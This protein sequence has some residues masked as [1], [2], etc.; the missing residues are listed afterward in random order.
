[1]GNTFHTIAC[2]FLGAKGN[3]LYMTGT[4]DKSL[5]IAAPDDLGGQNAG[6]APTFL[7]LPLMQSGNAGGY[8]LFD[9]GVW[10]GGKALFVR[11]HGWGLAITGFPYQAPGSTEW[12]KLA[13]P[14]DTA[15]GCD[16]G[17]CIM[18]DG[19]HIRALT[20]PGNG[21]NPSIAAVS[22]DLAAGITGKPA[23]VGIGA[24][25]HLVLVR[26]K[27]GKAYRTVYVSGS[28]SFSGGW[29]DEGGY[30]NAGASPTCV[31]QGAQALCVI[32]GNDGRL[33]AKLL[34][35]TSGL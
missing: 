34:A 10:D 5:S 33:Y 6:A 17:T 27:D 7:K 4:D 32:Q 31:A 28:N 14:F 9:F 1:M 12:T 26:G 19:N 24:G 21:G 16:A 15:P 29:K 11:R 35:G 13:M 25:K 18:V 20:I 22:G 23:V 3:A 8:S 30:I 2:A